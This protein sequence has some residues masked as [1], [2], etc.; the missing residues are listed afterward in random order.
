MLIALGLAIGCASPPTLVLPEPPAF[1][2]YDEHITQ[3]N[4]TVR[5]VSEWGGAIASGDRLYYVAYITKE[6]IE[7]PS[8]FEKRDMG[9]PLYGELWALG[10][11]RQ[12]HADPAV[13]RFLV[14]DGRHHPGT[15]TDP[16]RRIIFESEDG[17][18]SRRFAHFVLEP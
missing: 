13:Y 17:K 15:Q 11:Q 18:W 3:A 10:L 6:T 7:I 16:A 8:A 9:D 14:I 2:P 5:I 4:R 1:T 12:K